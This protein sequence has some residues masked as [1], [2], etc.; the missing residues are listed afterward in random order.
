MTYNILFPIE[1]SAR[2]LL[3]K[4]A[5]ASLFTKYGHHCY[6]GSK[7]EIFTLIDKIEKIVYFEKS[8]HEGN[9]EHI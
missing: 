3:Y 5:L 9:S 1:I 4:T 6:I 7:T 8:Y 2:E